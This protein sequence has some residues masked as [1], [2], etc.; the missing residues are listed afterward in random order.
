MYQSWNQ[1][2][3]LHWKIDPEIIQESLPPGLHVDTHEG[4]AY[5]G[6]VPFFMQ[7]IRPRFLPRIP[8][9]SNFLEMNVRTYVYDDSGTP[10]VWFYSLDANRSIAV[11]VA[12]RFF[13][14]PYYRADMASQV[15]GGNIH[16]QCSPRRAGES[17]ASEFVYRGDQALALPKPGSLKYFL[18][19]RYVLFAHDEAANQ[20]YSGRV[21]HR[22]YQIETAIVSRVDSG[23][24]KLAG[25]EIDETCPDHSHFSTGVDVDLFAL[26]PLP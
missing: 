21:H 5:L 25:F 18:V 16:Y 12:R 20:L 9:I 10:G 19:E 11:A 24:L 2:L 14:L 26:K 8:G 15:N 1:L 6:L 3:F 13:H 7:D 4:A 17:A 22:P 23:A